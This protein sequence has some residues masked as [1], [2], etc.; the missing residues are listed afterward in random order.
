MIVKRPVESFRCEQRV[1]TVTLHREWPSGF[2]LRVACDLTLAR[3]P[4]C[5][6]YAVHVVAELAGHVGIKILRSA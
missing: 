2:M 4:K 6:D 5:S 3:V 1:Y